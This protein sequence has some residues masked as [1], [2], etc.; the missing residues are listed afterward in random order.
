MCLQCFSR[1]NGRSSRRKDGRMPQRQLEQ[2]FEPQPYWRDSLLRSSV[3]PCAFSSASRSIHACQRQGDQNLLLKI[4]LGT[5]V[6]AW[7]Q[8]SP[9]ATLCIATSR[10]SA[11]NAFSWVCCAESC[12]LQTLEVPKNSGNLISTKHTI[13]G[14][15]GHNETELFG[16][17]F[18]PAPGKIRCVM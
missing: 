12:G 8:A 9:L 4:S 16:A 2:S 10:A 15:S 14:S 1:S 13:H 3:L 7:S 5:S 11:S 18:S 6:V 17:R